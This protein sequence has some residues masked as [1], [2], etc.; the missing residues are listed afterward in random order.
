MQRAVMSVGTVTGTGS[1]GAKLDMVRIDQL[2]YFVLA[3]MSGH[4][5]GKLIFNRVQNS[6]ELNFMAI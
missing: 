6:F 4:L 3:D 2:S 5:R 1:Y